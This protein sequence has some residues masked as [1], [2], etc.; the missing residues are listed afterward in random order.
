MLD[1]VLAWDWCRRRGWFA[2]LG[3]VDVCH[4]SFCWVCAF[5]AAGKEC[6]KKWSTR[7]LCSW[8]CKE[9]RPRNGRHDWP[10]VQPGG[11]EVG[12]FLQNVACW[13]LRSA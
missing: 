8:P 5:K 11:P 6:K 4:L 10:C 3:L 13:L 9:E 1:A 2:D 12:A 7:E